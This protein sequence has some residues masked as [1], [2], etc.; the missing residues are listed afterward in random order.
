MSTEQVEPQAVIPR[1]LCK[2]FARGKC[3]RGDECNFIHVINI[4]EKKS[5]KKPKQSRLVVI[6]ENTTPT[7]LIVTVPETTG[8]A[9]KPST[10]MEATSDKKNKKKRPDRKEKKSPAE[11]EQKTFQIKIPYDVVTKLKEELQRFCLNSIF[12]DSSQGKGISMT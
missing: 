1:T 12:M 10:T 11:S 4:V 3:S 9:V 7:T 6:E 8:V 5:T 2:F